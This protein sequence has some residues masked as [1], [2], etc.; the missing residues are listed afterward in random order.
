M[1]HSA[2][3]KAN[4]LEAGVRAGKEVDCQQKASGGKDVALIEFP[5]P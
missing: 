2:E 5:E 3:R 1:A 4:S